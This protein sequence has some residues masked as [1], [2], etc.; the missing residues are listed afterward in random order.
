MPNFKLHAF[1]LA[2]VLSAP[3]FAKGGWGLELLD[4]IAAAQAAP[5]P[6]S[7]SPGS[8][9]L[10]AQDALALYTPEQQKSGFATCAQ[11]FP[12]ATPL[13][14]TVVHPD[15]APVGLC[16]DEF[17]VVYSAATKTPLVV[18]ERL[19][20]KSVRDAKGEERTDVFFADPRVPRSAQAQLADYKTKQ[21]ESPSDR[22][23][24]APAG[25]ATN[26]QAMAQTFALSNMV[27]QDPENNRGPW[28]KIETDTR[29]Y[30]A[31]AGGPVFVFTGPIFAPGQVT[32]VG[33]SR[34]WRPS[35]LY[36]LVYDSART[37]AWAYVMQNAPGP[38][39]RP[40]D[41]AEFVKVTGLRLLAGQPVSGAT[42]P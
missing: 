13:A 25:N 39:P 5:S 30:A 37:R 16:S 21:G 17:A 18:V 31:R 28:R 32:T 12:G 36:K 38:V 3:A 10:S 22:G 41:Y 35:H 26:P 33:T 2:A 27:P 9:P 23:H 8:G 14:L 1:L 15:Y 24:M 20:A 6:A 40:M 34:V 7:R 29:K 4:K 11:L 42:E 19:T